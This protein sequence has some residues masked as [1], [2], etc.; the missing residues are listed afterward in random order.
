MR[1]VSALLLCLVLS[2]AVPSALC[3]GDIGH[4][5]IASIAN[6]LI[7]ANCSECADD[8]ANILP[9][10]ETME[11]VST[12]ADQVREDKTWKWTAPLHYVDTPDWACTF[13]Y[14]QDCSD[15]MCVVGALNNFTQQINGLSTKNSINWQLDSLKF[16]I[17]F[18]GDCHQPLHVAFASDEGGN[19]IEGTFEGDSVNLH[20][21]WDTSIIT[22]RMADDFNG[23][24]DQYT[25]YLLGQVQG[26]WAAQA[27]KWAVCPSGEV[28]CA[29]QWADETAALACSNAYKDQDGNIIQDNF[30]L[31]DDYYNFNSGVV[32]QQLATAAVR[33]SATLQRVF[34]SSR[35]LPA[36]KRI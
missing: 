2:S 26:P 1:S 12:W 4:E 13:N 22:K 7:N 17:H 24:Q 10:N 5:V 16:V 31:G 20:S 30:D 27:A 14:D 32:D 19:T 36:N 35:N 28:V 21:I 23:D 34:A 6:S 29:D 3:W 25:A 11:S 33:L 8:I 15:D 9:S 18:V